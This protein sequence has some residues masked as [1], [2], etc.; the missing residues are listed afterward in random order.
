MATPGR[1]RH[2][3]AAGGQRSRRRAAPLCL[4]RL[5]LAVLAAGLALAGGRAAAA[6]IRA[7]DFDTFGRVI[8]DFGETTGYSVEVASNAVAITFDQPFPE[9]GVAGL[10]AASVRLG[11]FVSGASFSPDRTVLILS[12]TGPMRVN[13]FAMGDGIAIDLWRLS[14]D[15]PA[16]AQPAEAAE[17]EVAEAPE[18]EQP[19]A[20][21]DAAIYARNR[22]SAPATGTS[23][24]TSRT[25]RACP[26]R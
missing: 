13:D 10:E 17:P 18:A 8:V 7:W 12:T 19:A 21:G 15:T 23:P 4:A 2:R 11:R 3:P 1:K 22:P 25:I 9:D 14:R 6:E 26:A 20:P 24:A 5:C 16:A